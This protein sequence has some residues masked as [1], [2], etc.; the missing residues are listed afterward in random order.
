MSLKNRFFY[1]KGFKFGTVNHF[2]MY[3]VMVDCEG[4]MINSLMSV[5][6]CLSENDVR[7]I[8]SELL[9]WIEPAVGFRTNKEDRS[10]IVT[11][12]SVVNRLTDVH[13]LLVSYLVL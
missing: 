11:A 10:F 13:F 7:P 3:E 2:Q 8:V 5:M 12:F 6:E 1:K 4:R 9:K